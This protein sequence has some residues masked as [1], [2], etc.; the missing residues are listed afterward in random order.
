MASLK[1]AV[2]PA[3]AL[4]I[5]LA[6]AA[7]VA[8]HEHDVDEQAADHA[9]CDTCHFQH[10]AGVEAGGAPAL[11]APDP[12]AAAVVSASPNGGRAA[13]LGGCPTRG[14]PA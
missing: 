9:N 8:L 10:L 7:D 2:A 14:P 12:V 3:V 13:E 4:C 11:S 1:Q 6:S 5:G